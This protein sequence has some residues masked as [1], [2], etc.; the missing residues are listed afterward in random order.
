MAIW[1][2]FLRHI[3]IQLNTKLHVS[4][5]KC[6]NETDKSQPISY[7]SANQLELINYSKETGFSL[8]LFFYQFQHLKLQ[9]NHECDLMLLIYKLNWILFFSKYFHFMLSFRLTNFYL[10]E[11]DV[12]NRRKRIIEMNSAERFEV[13]ISWWNE[14]KIECIRLS[15]E[16]AHKTN[17]SR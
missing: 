15:N 8:M 10:L 1:T 6:Q 7:V 2:H 3:S 12:C 4:Q 14:T 16:N 17:D 13:I 5:M 9:Q 11:K